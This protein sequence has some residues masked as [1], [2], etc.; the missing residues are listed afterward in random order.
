MHDQ[1]KQNERENSKNVLKNIIKILSTCKIN[2][3]LKSSE[4]KQWKSFVRIG[5]NFK[6]K[7][8]L[9]E[10]I[11]RYVKMLSLIQRQHI[12]PFFEH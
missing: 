12:L 4:F 5:Q 7:M 10:K 8:A 3:F 9:N 11:V 6:G 1:Q 2:Y